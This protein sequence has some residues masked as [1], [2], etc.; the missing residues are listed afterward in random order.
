MSAEE[1]GRLRD[2]WYAGVRA[3]GMDATCAPLLLSLREVPDQWKN[4]YSK[5][6]TKAGTPRIHAKKY[7]P[8][9]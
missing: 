5:T 4:R 9:I 6:R 8:M 3:N 7:L 2:G 1:A